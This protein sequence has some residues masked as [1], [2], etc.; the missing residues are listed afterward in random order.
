[1]LN[2]IW[3]ALAR[4]GTF[5]AAIWP[6]IT[7]PIDG[8]FY[9]R[10]AELGY[11]W[12]TR[13]PLSLWFHPLL[14]SI[15]RVLPDWL[16]KSTWFW[17]ISIAFALACLPLIFRL[18]AVLTGG[19][20]IRAGMLPWC[21]LAPGGLGIAT[22][23]A[24]IPTLFFVALLLLSVL[25]WHKWWL[26]L[27]SAAAAIL[28]KP[29]ALYMVPVLFIYFVSAVAMR[30]AKLRKQSLI[31]I[32]ALLVGW[33]IWIW[34]IDWQTGY[35]GAY[36]EARQSFRPYFGPAD[37]RGFFEQWFSAFFV[38]IDLR[39]QIRFSTAVLI[40]IANLIVIG[41]VPLAA[42]HHRYALAAGNLSM[43][44]I[45][46]LLGNPNKILLYSTTLPGYFVTHLVLLMWL[47]RR[48]QQRGLLSPALLR[49]LYLIYC[50]SMQI[51]YIVGTPLAW[52]Y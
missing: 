15:L 12:S 48:P 29:N 19:T 44:A 24:E 45:S 42:E 20:A 11:A 23:N 9:I 39:N 4:P 21:L 28:T 22:G 50:V 43:L 51:V 26:T 13:D 8:I 38:D 41:L 47:D 52:Y 35:T 30:D 18:T 27:V 10:N 14:S 40:P 3:D 7:G 16:P 33:L 5:P 6:P 49:A 37:F 17:I 32:V 34:I 36:W 46:L 31:G 1:M 2:P 25:V